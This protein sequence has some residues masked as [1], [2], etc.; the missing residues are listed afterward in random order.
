MLKKALPI[1]FCCFIICNSS[2]ALS[3][4]VLTEDARVYGLIL[5]KKYDLAISEYNRLIALYPEYAPFYDGLGQAYLNKKQ[6]GQAYVL[7]KKAQDFDQKN[8]IYKIHAQNAVYLGN[9]N[10]IENAKSLIIKSLKL[11]ANNYNILENYKNLDNNKFTSLN[12]ISDMYENSANTSLT[13]ANSEFYL[14][15]YSEAINSY[16]KASKDPVYAYQ[17]YNN[18]GLLYLELKNYDNAISS[19]N[20]AFEFNPK[21]AFVLNNLGLAYYYKND[22]VQAKKYFEQSIKINF[23]IFSAQNNKAVCLLS[24]MSGNLSNSINYLASI[25]KYEKQNI[26][27][28]RLYADFLVLNGDYKQ[29]I[30]LYKSIVEHLPDNK[31]YLKRLADILCLNS[32]YMDS[33]NYYKKVIAVDKTDIEACLG[34][35][36]A[37]EKFNDSKNAINYYQLALNLNPSNPDV[38]KYYGYFLVS[39]NSQIEAE[40]HFKKFISLARNKDEA[41]LIQSLFKI[42][43]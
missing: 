22:Y 4:D 8:S 38:Y 40:K 18:L 43:S 28:K 10:T 12:T 16:Q 19:F 11:S 21:E 29:S 14:K 37:Y 1:I 34:A 3:R 7:F 25:V 32:E 33:I 23:S 39:Q 6:Y 26:A 15:K 24:E 42:A 2:L 27:A 30:E 35:A 9:L 36:R 31:L 5:V 17:A 13:K 41:M 20:K